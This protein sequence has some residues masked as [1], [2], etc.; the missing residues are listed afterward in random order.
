MK[1]IYLIEKS[2]IDNLENRNAWGYKIVGF[3]ETLEEAEKIIS[4]GGKHKKGDCWEI[5]MDVRIGIL[6]E[7]PAKYKYKKIDRIII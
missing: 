2:W 7:Y 3:V 6:K 5:N 4:E 1:T